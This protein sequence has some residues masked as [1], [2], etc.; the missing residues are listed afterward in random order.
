MLISIF[1]AQVLVASWDRQVTEFNNP[2]IRSNGKVW[3]LNH[4]EALLSLCVKIPS[5]LVTTSRSGELGFWRLETGQLIKKHKVR[6]QPGGTNYSKSLASVTSRM[7]T[8]SSFSKFTDASGGT[9]QTEKDESVKQ[10]SVEHFAAVAS[11][12]LQGRPESQRSGDLAIATRNGVVQLWST[13]KVPRY[14]AKF[15]AIHVKDDYVTAMNSDPKSNYLFTSLYSGY[16]KTWYI[17]NFG[18]GYPRH[19]IP[20]FPMLSLRLRFPFLL[21]SSLFIGRAQRAAT[22]KNPNG[23]LLVNSYRAHTKHI[24]H[25]EYIDRLEIVVTSSVD[26]NIRLWTL[27][28]QYVGTLGECNGIEECPLS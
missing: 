5:L 23:P 8:T 12:F 24:N 16:V 18:A 3:R 27:A 26:K 25:I 4:N 28:G 15:V 6:M 17:A 7:S 20:K 19:S 21:D 1:C 13:F 9:D 11:H 14:V 10:M 2:L 22:S